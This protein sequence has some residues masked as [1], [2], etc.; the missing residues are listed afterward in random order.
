MAIQTINIGQVAN[1]G[2]GDDLRTAFDKVN[3]NFG[4]LD[5]RFPSEATGLNLGDVGEGIFT[6]ANSSRLSFKKLI[7]G[8]NITF[9]VNE[10]SIEIN[11]AGSL[12]QLIVV[13]DSGSIT[14][15]RGQSMAINGGTGLSTR[16]Q[17]QNL[18]IDAGA[19]VVAADT[20][21]QLSAQ[22]D[23][24]NNNII[25]GGNIT[26]TQFNGPLEGLVY[27]IDIRDI[28]GFYAD[29]DFGEF[30]PVYESIAEWLQKEVDVD[31]GTFV[32]PGLVAAEIELGTF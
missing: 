12:D 26:A 3:D 28:S 20:S 19:G 10:S 6:E 21:P 23:A 9:D 8:T 29:F 2:T 31:L 27:G 11:G 1:D 24:N 17:G 25:N 22:L 4:E 7:A 14:V 30:V 32:T 16:T 13:S 18:V 5:T 15:A